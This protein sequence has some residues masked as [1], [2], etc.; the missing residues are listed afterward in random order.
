MASTFL[1]L[2]LSITGAVGI[3]LIAASFALPRSTYNRIQATG[4]GPRLA[5]ALD[6]A[7]ISSL[8]IDLSRRIGTEGESL[9]E[10]LRRA[11]WIYSSAEEFHTRRMLLSLTYLVLGVGVS[12]L[13]A[14]F[15]GSRML[16][17]AWAMLGTLAALYGFTLPDRVVNRAIQRRKDRLV[18]EMGFGLERIALM[19]Q[20]G[21][22]IAEALAS[23][24]SLGLFG[25]ACDKLAWGIS[26]GRSINEVG[27]EL[28][29]ELPR[30]PQF[31]EFLGMLA[32][33]IHKGSPL[34]EAFQ[35]RA[36]LARGKL[37]LDII[38]AGQRAK[39]KVVLLTSMVILLASII[40][41]VLPTLL[42]LVEEGLF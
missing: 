6:P 38:E 22:D 10:R 5:G 40:V 4:S 42:M 25:T 3:L 16:P 24:R 33:S 32:V 8:L 31:D 20:S 35:A 15:L 19:L 17:L 34:V 30:S 9:D 18:R 21:A 23:A 26:M 27:E 1:H 14:S 41:T 13:S 28:R 39:I 29:G 37:K 7:L 12:A 11:G 2:L 36:A